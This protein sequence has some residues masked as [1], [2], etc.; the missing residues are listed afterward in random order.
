MFFKEILG[1][2]AKL[3]HIVASPYEFLFSELPGLSG[4]NGVNYFGGK[5][6]LKKITLKNLQIY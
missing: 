5:L 1:S 6:F 2:N 4:Y 3:S